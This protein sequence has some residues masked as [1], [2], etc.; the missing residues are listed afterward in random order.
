MPNTIQG[1]VYYTISETATELGVTKNTIRNYL[2]SGKLKGYRFGYPILI[3][4]A[5]IRN[6][7]KEYTPKPGRPRKSG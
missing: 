3:K 2:R 6:L 1:V 5:D 4:E 7:I